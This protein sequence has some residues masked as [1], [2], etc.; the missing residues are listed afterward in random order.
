MTIRK[1]RI[2]VKKK[3]IALLLSGSVLTM[4]LSGCGSSQLTEENAAEE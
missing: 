2:D 1:G 3:L 4:A